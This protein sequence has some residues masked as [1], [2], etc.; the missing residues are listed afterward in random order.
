MQR[1]TPCLPK[2][3]IDCQ[4]GIAHPLLVDK[5]IGP[6]WQGG[7]DNLRHGVGQFA[8]A[9]FAGI[10]GFLVPLAFRDINI[11]THHPY[12]DA[13]WI[14]KDVR[15]QIHPADIACGVHNPKIIVERRQCLQ[16][17]CN[18]HLGRGE[19]L[20]INTL[21]P[22]FIAAFKTARRQSVELFERGS[23]LYFVGLDIPLESTDAS[24][25]LRHFEALG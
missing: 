2:P 7:V 10:E 12:G 18:S 15:L 4:P 11:D 22:I 19:I 1:A 24:G 17:V 5:I 20:G 21:T 8:V 16:G 3:G 14:G 13:F 6:I 23:P 25:I 9:S